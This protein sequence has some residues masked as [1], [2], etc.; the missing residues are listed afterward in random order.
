MFDRFVEGQIQAYMAGKSDNELLGIVDRLVLPHFKPSQMV[1]L[2][3]L[4]NE[5][6][7]AVAGPPVVEKGRR[8]QAPGLETDPVGEVFARYGRRG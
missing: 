1:L 4:L 3:D 6:I 2:R 5:K 7:T 8:N